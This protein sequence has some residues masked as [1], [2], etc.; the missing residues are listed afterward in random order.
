MFEKSNWLRRRNAHQTQGQ[1]LQ[2][3]DS[4][5]GHG[6]GTHKGTTGCLQFRCHEV[7]EIEENVARNRS[8][9]PGLQGHTLVE[10]GTED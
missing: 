3:R 10:H 8:L 7:P 2:V 6:H 9:S 5:S 1:V 4:F